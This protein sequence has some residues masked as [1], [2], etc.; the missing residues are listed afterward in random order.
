MPDV[1]FSDKFLVLYY[2]SL[3]VRTLLNPIVV[4]AYLS[5]Y[6]SEKTISEIANDLDLPI[7]TVQGIMRKM[8]NL[9]LVVKLGEKDD[10]R[11]VIY[12][13][14][15]NILIKDSNDCPSILDE[16]VVFNYKNTA[17]S[18]IC[19]TFRNSASYGIDYWYCLDYIGSVLGSSSRNLVSIELDAKQKTHFDVTPMFNIPVKMDID[20]SDALIVKAH[21][22]TGLSFKE[23]LHVATLTSAMMRQ[24]R[25]N[26]D[27]HFQ[28]FPKVTTNLQSDYVKLTYGRYSTH[29]GTFTP[30]YTTEKYEDPTYSMKS[31][32]Y[33]IEGRSFI[34]RNSL[35]RSIL[36]ILSEKDCKL[37]YLIEMLQKSKASIFNTLSK[38]I[39]VGAVKI[40]DPSMKRNRTYSLS[41]KKLLTIDPSC[42]IH[43]SEQAETEYWNNCNVSHFDSFLQNG[44]QHI[45]DQAGIKVE[46]S[47][48]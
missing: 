46:D 21:S 20:Y 33:I 48:F 42:C 18:V 17:D 13:P 40:V 45:F 19:R 26:T 9:G 4:R 36:D 24:L 39:S 3:G 35:M 37:S 15:L 16:S 14:C 44:L 11:K 25:G 2:P 29:I 12:H 47:S 32:I 38:L 6:E 41:C 30:Y 27:I 28:Y 23:I 1:E 22:K 10:S 7:T 34:I 43:I 8:T 5:L 31:E